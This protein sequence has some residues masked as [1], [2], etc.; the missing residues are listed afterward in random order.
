MDKDEWELLL[1]FVTREKRF[2]RAWETSFS[3]QQLREG[4]KT[5][6]GVLK[7]VKELAR[8]NLDEVKKKAAARE[9]IVKKIAKGFKQ[10][11]KKQLSEIV[12]NFDVFEE[13]FLKSK[14]EENAPLDKSREDRYYTP[15]RH[16]Y[17]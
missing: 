16:K 8:K 6:K 13:V 5:F 4:E 14:K 17:R 10:L 9:W 12:K 1:T 7:A 2:L 3:A 11:S 15:K